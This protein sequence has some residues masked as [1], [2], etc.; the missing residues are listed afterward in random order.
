M[1]S[2]GPTWHQKARA[3]RGPGQLLKAKAGRRRPGPGSGNWK[4]RR[5]CAIGP[6]RRLG[7]APAAGPGLSEPAANRAGAPGSTPSQPGRC[8]DV[9]APSLGARD[10]GGGG[11]WPLP[12]AVARPLPARAWNAQAAGRPDDAEYCSGEGRHRDCA[13][14]SESKVKGPSF[15]SYFIFG[16]AVGCADG[17]SLGPKSNPNIRCSDLPSRFLKLGHCH[18][19]KLPSH[20]AAVLVASFA[21]PSPP[22]HLLPDGG[23]LN[24]GA[25]LRLT[26]KH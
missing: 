24:G 12:S 15:R 19:G 10:G 25:R 2:P 8:R 23:K 9:G 18:C 22:Q 20:A 17:A 1:P 14:A 4:L 16:P 26:M 11:G 6:M 21:C 13:V 7:N 5:T 3:R